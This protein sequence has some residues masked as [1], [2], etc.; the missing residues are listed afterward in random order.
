M[1]V[2][3]GDVDLVVGK[4]KELLFSTGILLSFTIATFLSGVNHFVQGYI[5]Q[6]IAVNNEVVYINVIICWCVV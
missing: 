3:A 6:D 1:L 4:G 5:F 2:A